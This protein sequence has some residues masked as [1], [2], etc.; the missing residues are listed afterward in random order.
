VLAA[1]GLAVALVQPAKA[2]AVAAMWTPEAMRDAAPMDLL[3]ADPAKLTDDVRK[4]VP[5]VRPASIPNG[6]AAWTGG[7]KVVS[8][9]GRGFFTYQGPA[10]LVLRRRGDQR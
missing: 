6:G 1:A 5:Q 4:G 9:A 2:A 7:G 3:T 8:T 10:G